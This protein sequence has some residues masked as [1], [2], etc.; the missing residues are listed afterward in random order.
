MEFSPLN[1]NNVDELVVTP[2]NYLLLAC[3]F[4]NEFAQLGQGYRYL[5]YWQYHPFHVLWLMY[6]F[7]GREKKLAQSESEQQAVSTENPPNT[8]D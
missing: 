2:R 5:N 7:G 6:S 1:I 4:I 8:S 3:H